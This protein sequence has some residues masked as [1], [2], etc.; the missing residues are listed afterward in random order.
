MRVRGMCGAGCGG[1]CAVCVRC[2]CGACAG[3]V[4]GGAR[5]PLC[6]GQVPAS[7]HSV[8][9]HIPKPRCLSLVCLVLPF[10]LIRKTGRGEW[11]GFP[12]LRPQVQRCS[13]GLSRCQHTAF[14]GHLGGLPLPH[15]CRADSWSK[16][17]RV[18]EE[19]IRTHRPAKRLHA[20]WPSHVGARDLP[21]VGRDSVTVFGIRAVDHGGPVGCPVQGFC[22]PR[23]LGHPRPNP[24]AQPGSA[25]PMIYPFGSFLPLKAVEVKP[26]PGARPPA[27]A[28]PGAPLGVQVLG[29]DVSALVRAPTWVQ[30]LGRREGPRGRRVRAGRRC[31]EPP[32]ARLPRAAASAPAHPGR[33]AR[34]PRRA[35]MAEGR[36]AV[37]LHTITATASFFL[38]QTVHKCHRKSGSPFIKTE[39][40]V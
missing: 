10:H 36:T 40:C 30:D 24:A 27:G 17:L 3:R 33:G 23:A 20:V 13:A 15:L 14:R 28:A 18:W 29:P 39:K 25:C 31:R 37:V 32:G 21:R 5:R 22:D 4:R 9:A 16:H 35:R 26:F 19:D 34:L 6:V 12:G 7:V 38:K 8:L 1:L 2:A 11:R